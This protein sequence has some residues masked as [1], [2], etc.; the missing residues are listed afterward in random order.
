MKRMST[1]SSGL[2]DL[3]FG[4]DFNVSKMVLRPSIVGY[5]LA[6]SLLSA[7]APSYVLS[8]MSFSLICKY[9]D[10]TRMLLS[11]SVLNRCTAS[12]CALIYL[13]SNFRLLTDKFSS[14]AHTGG[15]IGESERRHVRKDV[16]AALLSYIHCRRS[17]YGCLHALF[18]HC[19]TWS[20]SG[21]TWRSATSLTGVNP[22]LWSA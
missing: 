8:K 2:T 12:T 9:F 4:S 17:Q 22:I 20:G 13:R 16:I 1:I 21:P 10:K 18:L 5:C 6:G 14:S 15:L 11:R 7:I 19:A 3:A